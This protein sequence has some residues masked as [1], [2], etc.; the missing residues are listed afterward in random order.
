MGPLTL[1]CRLMVETKRKCSTRTVRQGLTS[2]FVN[3]T[4]KNLCAAEMN[5]VEVKQQ[6][7]MLVE[8]LEILATL[9]IDILELKEWRT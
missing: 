4:H 3:T 7:Q 8:K 6:K 5:I 1:S 2:T 9:G